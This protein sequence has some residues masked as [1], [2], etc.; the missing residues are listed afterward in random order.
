VLAGHE[1]V[2]ERFAPQ[3]PAG[4]ADAARGIRQFTVGTGGASHYGFR[5]TPEPTSEVRNADAYGV[6][7]LTLRA[8]GY[9]W[10]FVPIAGS[11]FTDAGSAGCG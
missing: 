8:D 3:T 5:A 10:R 4:I 2:Y 6:L 9:D 1:H 11:T 7:T